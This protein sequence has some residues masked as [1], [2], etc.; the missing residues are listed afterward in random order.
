MK[1]AS[2][3]YT[4]SPVDSEIS[5]GTFANS[6]MRYETSSPKRHTVVLRGQTEGWTQHVSAEASKPGYINNLY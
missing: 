4:D 5:W 1:L 6:V 2:S 3:L